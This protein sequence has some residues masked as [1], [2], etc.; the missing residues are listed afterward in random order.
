[1]PMV[2]NLDVYYSLGTVKSSVV[3]RCPPD[4]YQLPAHIATH[5]PH[6]LHLGATS[7][8]CI[9]IS[10]QINDAPTPD[11]CVNHEAGD[12]AAMWLDSV[13]LATFQLL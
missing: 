3:N 11:A 1:M 2:A 5:H 7:F 6:V 8:C 12:G 10:Y 13:N 4:N 9:T